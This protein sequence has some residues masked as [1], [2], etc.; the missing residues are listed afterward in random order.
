MM[1]NILM[2]RDKKRLAIKLRL[3][4]YS[5]NDIRTKVA[6]SKST[7]SLWLGNYPLSPDQLNNLLTQKRSL[8]TERFRMA[9]QKKRDARIKTAHNQAMIDL[10]PLSERDLMIAGLFLYL[11][12]GAKVGWSRI[13]ISNTDPDIIKFC[14]FWLTKILKINKLKLRAQ[15]HLYRDM[16]VKKEV[17]FWQGVTGFSREQIIKPYIKNTSSKN[18]DHPSFGHGTCN[19]YTCNV[20]LKHKIMAGFKV[21]LESVNGRII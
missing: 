16:N 9:M 6:V 8:Q 20:D 15:I 10:M 17:E 14:V 4:G 12:E 13:Q 21:I 1:Y 3:A 18:I 7:L 5:Y 11:G 19:V 2:F